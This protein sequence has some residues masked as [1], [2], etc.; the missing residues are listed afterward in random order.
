MWCCQRGTVKRVLGVGARPAVDSRW[1]R[2]PSGERMQGGVGPGN[3]SGVASGVGSGSGTIPATS[4]GRLGVTAA[5]IP[6]P[7]GRLVV[8]RARS[9]PDPGPTLRFGAPVGRSGRHLRPRGPRRRP[10]G[11]PALQAARLQ[12][13]ADRH[14]FGGPL[15]RCGSAAPPRCMEHPAQR[16]AGGWGGGALEI[17]PGSTA[18]RPLIDPGTTSNPP[19]SRPGGSAIQDRALAEPPLRW[20]LRRAEWLDAA[21]EACVE[22]AQGLRF[23][24]K[25]RKSGWTRQR[26]APGAQSVA[27]GRARR[28]C[29]LT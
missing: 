17:D 6:R 16:E 22:S 28:C 7:R 21:R 26:E 15:Q 9:G 23:S 12:R 27:S 25:N 10:H 11:P 29:A 18:K 14:R 4:Q 20:I 5:W 13:R 8:H 19:R 2:V 1:C 24:S 3:P